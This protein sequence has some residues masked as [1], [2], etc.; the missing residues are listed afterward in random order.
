MDCIVPFP[1]SA[2]LPQAA[3]GNVFS[4][5]VIVLEVTALELDDCDGAT[6]GCALG[7]IVGAFEGDLVGMTVGDT[8]GDTVACN[9][10]EYVL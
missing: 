4:D 1:D 5:H 2:T 7:M 8:V 6:V 3:T 9:D 10:D